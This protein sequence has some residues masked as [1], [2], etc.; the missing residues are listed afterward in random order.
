MNERIKRHLESADR[1]VNQRA[2][3]MALVLLS[4][5]GDRWVRRTGVGLT[6]V[7][8]AIYAGEAVLKISQGQYR[9][10]LIDALI[11]TGFAGVSY[12]FNKASRSIHQF[13]ERDRAARI[14]STS[15]SGQ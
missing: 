8:S 3:E 11:S 6:A 2:D 12:G 13:V 15:S 10:A 9:Q 7:D 14:N 1:Y 5:L 4:F